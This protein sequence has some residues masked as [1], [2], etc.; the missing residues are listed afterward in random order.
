MNLFKDEKPAAPIKEEEKKE[1][2]EEEVCEGDA[3]ETKEEEDDKE[4]DPDKPI[5]AIRLAAGLTATVA[6]ASFF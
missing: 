1:E 4:T 3:C 6:A 2:E 5:G